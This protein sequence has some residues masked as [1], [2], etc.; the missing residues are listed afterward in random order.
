MSSKKLLYNH[1]WTSKQLCIFFMNS[2]LQ[3]LMVSN[4]SEAC[5]GSHKGENPITVGQILLPNQ[6]VH[7]AITKDF[8]AAFNN[9][10]LIY[11]SK[12]DTYST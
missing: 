8:E 5:Q 10:V 12:P 1:E 11:S 7:S 3:T 4:P 9:T 2:K 6:F